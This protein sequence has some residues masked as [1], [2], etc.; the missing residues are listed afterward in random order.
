MKD[1]YPYLAEQRDKILKVIRQEETQFARTLGG[2]QGQ[3][4]AA[5]APLSDGRTEPSCGPARTACLP[6]PRSCPARSP[7]GSTTRTASRWT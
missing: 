2:G 4:E 3:L 6:M 7:S 5:L 1:A